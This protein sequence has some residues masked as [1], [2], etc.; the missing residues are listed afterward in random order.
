ML[1]ALAG[2]GIA[3]L[4][5]PVS[6]RSD[7][8]GTSLGDFE[9]GLDG[10]KTN[11]GVK[12]SR[13]EYEDRPYAIESGDHA[14]EVSA[15][16]DPYP[17][18]A[19]RRRVRK[20][21]F[22]DNPYLLGH[23]TVGELTDE[24]ESITFKLRYHHG[25]APADG[26]GG[27][28]NQ[29]GKGSGNGSTQKSALVEEKEVTVPSLTKSLIQWDMSSL[30]EEKRS[31]PKRLEIAWYA[32]DEPKTGPRG[33]GPGEGLTGAVVFDAIR[34]TDSV[35]LLNIASFGNHIRDLKRQ[36]GTFEYETVEY[37]EGGEEGKLV[38]TDGTEV[39]VRWEDRGSDRELYT[40]GDTTFKLGGGWD[41]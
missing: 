12:L 32:G 27:G 39:P 16:G 19:N 8:G 21:D 22:V 35:Q 6:A 23:V 11:G 37:F 5:P 33:R 40:V 15:N 14:L 29:D 7:P 9:S 34:V 31:D 10:W 3:T 2:T 36:H 28:K 24:L 41:E 20:A 30:A 18:I 1:M 25:A 4:A 38:F 17:M 26:S 13:V